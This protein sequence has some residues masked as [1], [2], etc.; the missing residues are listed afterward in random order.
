M[1]KILLFLLLF[2]NL[3]IVTSEC[4]FFVTAGMEAKAQHMHQEPGDNCYDSEFGWYHSPFS[5]CRDT[6][7][8]AVE[9]F[10]VA[11][12]QGGGSDSGKGRVSSGGGGGGKTSSSSGTSS[13]TAS[14]KITNACKKAIDETKRIYGNKAACNVGVQCYFKELYGKLDPALNGY[15]NEIALQLSKSKNWQLLGSGNAGANKAA[16]RASDG[17]MVIGAW[18]AGPKLNGHVIVILPTGKALDCGPS[19]SSS[20]PGK[21]CDRGWGY[22]FGPDKRNNVF[23]YEYKSKY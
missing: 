18:Y 5:D 13:E 3:Q 23:F 10:E 4:D 8:V 14:N 9:K 20:S 2:V 1:K 17:N 19:V 12:I 11:T 21:R 15:A 22:S 7:V 6:E 16:K